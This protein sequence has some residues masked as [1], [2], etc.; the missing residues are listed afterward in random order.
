MKKKELKKLRSLQ[1]TGRMLELAKAEV[2]E[3]GGYRNQERYRHNLFMR[4]QV[5]KGILKAAL[6][7]TRDLRL[8]SRTPL[9][10][11]YVD[12]KARSFVTWDTVYG[13][14]REAKVDCLNLP[15]RS[16]E[17]GTYISPKDNHILKKYLEA[18]EDGY[19]GLL[20]YQ[21]VI[22]KEQL[23]KRQRK[24]T[25]A[26]DLYLAQ[27]PKLPDDW[28][29]WVDKEGMEQNYIF[30][31]YSRRKNQKGYC[32]WCEREV[33]IEKPRHNRETICPVCGHKAR[34]KARG[35]AGRFWT[36]KENVYLLQDCR[37]GMVVREFTAW[38]RYEKGTYETPER[39]CEE[40]RRVIFTE[41]LEAR[42]FYYG[43]Y[44][45]RIS[46]WI[47]TENWRGGSYYNYRQYYGRRYEGHVYGASM[48]EPECRRLVRTGLPQLLEKYGTMD[49]EQYLSHL[50]KR[51]YLEQLVKS[52]LFQLA[53]EVYMGMTELE[54]K[55]S[56]D[57][58]RSL[59]ID[60]Y[61][62]KRLREH[63]GGSRY[64]KWLIL[65][66]RQGKEISDSVIE[67]FTGCGIQE[68]DLDFISGRMSVARIKNFLE[69]QHGLS[70]RNPKELVGTWRDYLSMCT[71]LHRDITQEVF[72]KPGDLIRSHDEAVRLCKD[73][74]ITLQA[75]ETLKKYPDVDEIC[76]S[77][78]EKYEYA[79]KEYRIVVPERVEDII[80]EGQALRHCAD[81]SE[82]YYDRIQNRES[83]IMFLRKAEEPYRPYY[84]LEVEPDGTIRQKRT[85]GDR[86]NKD[87][88]DAVVFLRKW[89]KEIQKRLTREDRRLAQKSSRLRLEEFQELRD[90]K[91]RIWHGHLQGKLLADVLEADL[92]EAVRC[93]ETEEGMLEND[94]VKGT[95]QEAEG[96][97]ARALAVAA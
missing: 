53:W 64:L 28:E 51:P 11:V 72:F 93:M 60:R 30:Y 54:V 27:V 48:P 82:V 73:K 86:Q 43:L 39:F 50:K 5:E 35:R 36:E 44:K 23:E 42:T 31:D 52:G 63:N 79:D 65:E 66:K 24:E 8:G 40:N 80:Y 81:S 70:G 67:Y 75:A 88:E 34:L 69:R 85:V 32:S 74:E 9:Y 78:K 38:R 89:Q 91:A 68:E 59:G 97:E 87:L 19:E 25:D 18:S 95:G 41:G 29:K 14:W 21:L 2:P 46:R 58:A 22:R 33:P 47:E 45:Q 15:G 77:V 57:F 17:S 12:R 76:R 56:P 55:T 3:K 20:K 13:R 84:T 61:R 1:A 92:M 4:C 10:E 6:F 7:A 16:W 94:A 62:M 37:D 96:K 90:K 71:R 83:Y 26:W 49:P